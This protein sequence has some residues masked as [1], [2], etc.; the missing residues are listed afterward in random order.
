M[1]NV[2]YLHSLR[3]S[4]STLPNNT[5]HYAIGDIALW[6]GIK[7][8]GAAMH[9]GYYAAHNIHQTMQQIVN[10]KQEEEL[11][12]LNEIPPMIGLAVGKQAVAYWPENGT[13]YGEKVLRDFFGEDLG[14]T[15]KSPFL[16]V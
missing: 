1:S 15:S 10:G 5:H 13:I 2:A 12:E 6:S 11:L 14:F 7:R 16:R 3:F 8:C 9:M 4:P